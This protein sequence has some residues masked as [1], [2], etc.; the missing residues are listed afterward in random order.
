MTRLLH[1]ILVG[2]LEL[3]RCG[4]GVGEV[5][6]EGSGDETED[7]EEDDDFLGGRRGTSRR[8]RNLMSRMPS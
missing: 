3:L 2:G 6:E 8:E 1:H 5:G 7:D 4:D